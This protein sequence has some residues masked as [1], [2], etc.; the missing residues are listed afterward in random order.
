MV[1]MSSCYNGKTLAL[2]S[3]GTQFKPWPDYTTES[4][5]F[6]GFPTPPRWM[7]GEYIQIDHG[8]L[9]PNPYLPTIHIYLP[10]SYDI[11]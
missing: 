9:L 11:T 2:Y 10:I 5:V 8:Y 3:G 4:K 7:M 1:P 6:P